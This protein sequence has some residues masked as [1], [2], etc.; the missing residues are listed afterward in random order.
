GVAMPELREGEVSRWDQLSM[1]LWTIRPFQVERAADLSEG[2][3]MALDDRLSGRVVNGT[4]Y[5]LRDVYLQYHGWRYSV[6]ELP[7]GAVRNVTTAGWKRRR[8]LDEREAGQRSMTGYRPATQAAG[9]ENDD[10]FTT[11]GSQ[12]QGSRE[13]A[14]VL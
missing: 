3:R 2:V 7:P 1:A 11:A 12:L 5:R 6:D 8:L 14:E 13:R 9:R 4:S 10:L